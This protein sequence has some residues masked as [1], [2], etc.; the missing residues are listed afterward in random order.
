VTAT[1]H[2]TEV[3]INIFLLKMMSPKLEKISYIYSN[4]ILLCNLMVDSRKVIHTTI[5]RKLNKILWDKILLCYISK[6][7]SYDRL[8]ACV[9]RS[10]EYTVGNHVT[11]MVTRTDNMATETCFSGNS[12]LYSFNLHTRI[13]AAYAEY[14]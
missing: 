13:V 2:L 1:W 11:F 9:I 14:N 10:I 4:V 5:A 6:P 12:L 3:F 8:C 7:F